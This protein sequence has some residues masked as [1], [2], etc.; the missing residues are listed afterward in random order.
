MD[1][2]KVLND[3]KYTWA[4]IIIFCTEDDGQLLRTLQN[5]HKVGYLEGV[6]NINELY[7]LHDYIMYRLREAIGIG[8]SDD[9]CQVCGKH[10]R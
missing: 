10:L 2:E 3:N 4:D 7:E 8:G 9:V 5:M 6:N 1:F